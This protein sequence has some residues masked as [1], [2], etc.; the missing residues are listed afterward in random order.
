MRV[1]MQTSGGSIPGW[2]IRFMIDIRVGVPVTA[3]KGQM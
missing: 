1:Y 3:M 2:R